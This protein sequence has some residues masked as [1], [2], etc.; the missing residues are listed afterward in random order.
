VSPSRNSAG[1]DVA[2]VVEAALRI[3]DAEGVHA[4]TM[5]KLAS[6]LEVTPMAI[7]H[8]VAHKEELLDLVADES[9]RPLLSLPV[10]GDPGRRV[11]RFFLGLHHLHLAHPALPQVM[12]Q[13]P[14]EGPTATVLGERLLVVLLDAGLGPKDASRALVALTSYTLGTSLYRLSRAAATGR[15]GGVSE[16]EAPTAYRLQ[17]HLAAAADGD[18]QFLDG[19]RRLVASYGLTRF[20]QGVRG[21][22]T[23]S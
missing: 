1:L 16:V 22:N 6:A 15:F 7:Y 4:L 12:A 2:T 17:E 5:R 18:G 8:H 14:L 10:R 23:T 9:L 11:E 13:R 21:S 20:V 3:A 19:L